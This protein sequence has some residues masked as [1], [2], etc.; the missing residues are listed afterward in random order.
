MVSQRSNE[1]DQGPSYK[2]KSCPLYIFTESHNGRG[3]EGLDSRVESPSEL[4]F[5]RVDEG[6]EIT[7]DSVVRN[8]R[9]VLFGLLAVTT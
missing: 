7:S 3:S 1:I 8:W 9:S 5:T 6:R 2:P 4:C